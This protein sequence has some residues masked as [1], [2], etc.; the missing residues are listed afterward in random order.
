M[1]LGVARFALANCW[2]KI[3]RQQKHPTSHSQLLIIIIWQECGWTW[4][5]CIIWT[6][7]DVKHRLH[8]E[9]SSW[10]TAAI[11]QALFCYHG[12]R[13]NQRRGLCPPPGHASCCS[14]AAVAFLEC[15]FLC[16]C[17]CTCLCLF[18]NPLKWRRSAGWRGIPL[19]SVHA[20]NFFGWGLWTP[21]NYTELC[22]VLIDVIWEWHTKCRAHL[23]CMC[24]WTKSH[25][26]PFCSSPLLQ[27]RLLSFQRKM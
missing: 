24:M 17:S 12:Y 15:T 16:V 10:G 1:S 14:A 11:G 8:P 5:G 27:Q 26:E 20:A 21:V 19:L 22:E 6:A 25:R 4:V 9:L 7:L 2:T 23:D 13:P 18:L 3:R